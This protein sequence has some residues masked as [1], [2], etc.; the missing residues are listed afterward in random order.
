MSLLI[1]TFAFEMHIEAKIATL[2]RQRFKA[3][4]IARA[5]FEYAK[6]IL[7]APEQTEEEDVA[8]VVEFQQGAKRI[9]RGLNL[10]NLTYELP[11]GRFSVSIEHES[12]KRNINKL[13]ADEWVLL[14]EQCDIP[15]TE[16]NKLIDCYTDWIDEG[17]LHQLNG[18]ESD[19]PFYTELGYSCKNA[20]VET[21]KELLLIKNFTE[22]TLY[23]GTTEDGDE[24]SGIADKL[25][26][27]GDGKVNLNSASREVLMTFFELEEG[28]IDEIL[29]LWKGLD[30]EADTEDDGFSSL[31]EIG[32][33]QFKNKFTTQ[34]SH[35]RIISRARTENFVYEIQSVVHADGK[36]LQVLYWN[37]SFLSPDKLVTE[38]EQKEPSENL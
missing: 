12:G 4:E 32:L 24:I 10:S 17:D 33:N 6:A 38:P 1:G 13:L 2:E 14:L 21:I 11:D 23:G 15:P 22:A 3:Q 9:R 8:E 7:T 31:A 20:P 27:W 19:D 29:D 28:V 36:E 18:A 34:S 35:L 16:Q 5:G 25:T 26:V 30:G 37:E